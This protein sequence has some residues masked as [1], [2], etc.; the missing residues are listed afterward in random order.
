MFAP[1]PMLLANYNESIFKNNTTLYVS[2]KYDGWRIYYR[3][4]VFYTRAG[5]MLILP[6]EFGNA[7]AKFPQMEFDGELWMGYGTT[8][9]DVAG[10]NPATVSIKVFDVPNAGKTFE[11]R[12]QVLQALDFGFDRITQVKQ[13]LCSSP[14][15]M[16]TVYDDVLSRG[17]E[18]VVLRQPNQ[19]YTHGIRDA[20]FQ[21]K[22]PLETLEA[23]VVSHFRT[24]GSADAPLGYVSSLKVKALDGLSHSF[25]VS[26]RTTCPPP[27]GS[28][29][30]LRYMQTTSQ[31]LPKFP[32]L[33]GI[34][35]AADMPAEVVKAATKPLKP[36][37]YTSKRIVSHDLIEPL[38]KHPRCEGIFN[39]EKKGLANRNHCYYNNGR[40][41]YYKVSRVAQGDGY[42]C[43][44]DA[45]MWQRLPA[46]LRTCKHCIAVGNYRPVVSDAV[47]Q[48]MKESRNAE[49]ATKKAMRAEAVTAA[50]KAKQ[51]ARLAAKTAKKAAA[52]EARLAA[53]AAKKAAALEARLAAKA[54]ALETR[55]AAKTAKKAAAQ[56]ARLAA[57][58]AKKVLLMAARQN[59]KNAKT[60]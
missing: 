46:Q 18:G 40:G 41:A 21:K 12:L 49:M 6:Q 19:V 42:F 59:I 28:I 31:G 33:V 55:Q 38:L 56:E 24:A 22:K 11:E 44:C 14:K 45:W 60:Q 13:T 16:E 9:S 39:P 26:V 2:E 10:F 51:E 32:K 53:K 5:K 36:A 29:V 58:A 48:A 27:V 23:T 34:R 17:G 1:S 30:T 43:S 35:D 15:E 8:S 50:K 4:G 25:K 3:S 57:K 7:L 52:Q 37:T 54:A 47:R 20:S